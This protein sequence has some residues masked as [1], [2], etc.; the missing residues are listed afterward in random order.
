MRTE[1]SFEISIGHQF[2]NHQSWLGFRYNTKQLDHMMGIELPLQINKND[3]IV[4]IY[5]FLKL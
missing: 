2:H 3:E 4:E 1:V 5:I